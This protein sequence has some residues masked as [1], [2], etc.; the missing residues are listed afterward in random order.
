LVTSFFDE[1]NHT[2]VQKMI[3]IAHLLWNLA[4]PVVKQLSTSCWCWGILSPLHWR[5]IQP[6]QTGMFDHIIKY[7]VLNHHHFT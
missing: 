6:F 5:K 2:M 7:L 3:T 4:L 1:R